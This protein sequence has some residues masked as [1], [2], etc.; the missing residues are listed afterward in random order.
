MAALIERVVKAWWSGENV[1]L[2]AAYE[3]ADETMHHSVK[4]PVPV[5]ITTRAEVVQVEEIV[6]DMPFENQETFIV[7]LILVLATTFLVAW[8]ITSVIGQAVQFVRDVTWFA[9]R[10]GLALLICVLIFNAVTP[11]A[12][13]AKVRVGLSQI[14][15]AVYQGFDLRRM[16]ASVVA[17][18]P[19]MEAQQQFEEGDRVEVDHD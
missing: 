1:A 3:I 7:G 17:A 4:E 12:M 8:K 5:P 13:Q 9:M 15:V 16:A 14:I 19:R 6:N 10:L 18:L 11:P 2:E